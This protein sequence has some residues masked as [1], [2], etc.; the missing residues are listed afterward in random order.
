MSF[1]DVTIVSLD[2]VGSVVSRIDLSAD[3]SA[4][5]DAFTG[6][7]LA[8]NKVEQFLNKIRR[9][10]AAGVRISHK[11]TLRNYVE[12]RV[13]DVLVLDTREAAMASGDKFDY[14]FT[15][16][17]AIKAGVSLVHAYELLND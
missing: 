10:K 12:V 16:V 11:M 17:S 13:D 8:H 9:A 1:V 3:T 6:V 4:D 14:T 5:I 7:M 15:A 2:K